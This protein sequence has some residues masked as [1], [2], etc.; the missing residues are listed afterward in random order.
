MPTKLRGDKSAKKKS[1]LSKV[2]KTAPSKKGL[3][4]S[5]SRKR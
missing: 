2:K 3:T 4:P 5:K 1:M